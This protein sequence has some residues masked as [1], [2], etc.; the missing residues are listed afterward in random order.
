MCLLAF[1]YEFTHIDF[2]WELLMYRSV[3]FDHN[4]KMLVNILFIRRPSL[5]KIN[6]LFSTQVNNIL[7]SVD[8]FERYY[9]PKMTKF[10]PLAK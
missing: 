10:D 1:I 4:Y 7:L 3:V 8:R 2:Y 6:H 9:K 5:I